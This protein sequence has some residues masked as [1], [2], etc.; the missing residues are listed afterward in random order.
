MDALPQGDRKT[1][2]AYHGSPAE[3]FHSIL[4]HG[5]QQHLNKNALFGEGVYLSQELGVALGYCKDGRGWEGAE[6][7]GAAVSAVVLC[8]VIDHVDVKMHSEG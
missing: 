1:H 5:L 7:M 6:R 2:F 4:S 3:N 8:E